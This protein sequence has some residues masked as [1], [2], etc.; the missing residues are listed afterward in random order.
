MVFPQ[1]THFFIF[2]LKPD[3]WHPVTKATLKALMCFSLLAH[4]RF[5]LK[6]GISVLFTSLYS[7]GP[8]EKHLRRPGNI[9][10]PRAINGPGPLVVQ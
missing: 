5:D 6:K 1:S 9:L 7:E 8:I 4:L 10:T 3:V 2:Y